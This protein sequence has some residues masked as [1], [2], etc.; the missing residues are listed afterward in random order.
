MTSYNRS[1]S[2]PSQ[3]QN[4]SAAGAVSLVIERPARVYTVAA[5]STRALQRGF[6]PGYIRT[7]D[8]LPLAGDRFGYTFKWGQPPSYRLETLPAHTRF[9]GGEAGV[10]DEDEDEDEDVSVWHA[11]RELE[12]PTTSAMYLFYFGFRE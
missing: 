10:Q 5:A 2:E 12:E 1:T 6:T 4:D 11:G 7:R 3:Q 9:E 8:G